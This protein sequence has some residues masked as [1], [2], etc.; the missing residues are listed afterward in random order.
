MNHLDIAYESV[1]ARTK[2]SREAF[3]AVAST[4]ERHTVDVDGKPAGMI[5]VHGCE[6]HACI[7]EWAKGR[8]F[9]KKAVRVLNGVIERHGKATT[10]ATTPDGV[11]FVKRLGFVPYWNGWQRCEKWAS[12]R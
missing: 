6:I 4:C 10:S 9:G 7:A 12:K 1:A 5:L 2:I 11:E 8:W 3:D